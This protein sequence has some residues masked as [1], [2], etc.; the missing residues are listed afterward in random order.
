M[1]K[2]FLI[3][4]VNILI[5]HIVSAQSIIG[6]YAIQNTVSGKNLRPYDAGS[7]NGNR[8]VLYNHVEWKCMTWKFIQVKDSTY[9]LRNLFTSKTFQAADNPA[10]EGTSLEQ[11]PVSYDPRQ[12]WEFIKAS[13]NFYYI[14]LKGTG[15][16]ITASS[17]Q[18]NSNIVLQE[19]QSNA[20]QMWR[21]VAQNPNM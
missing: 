19:K 16:Y 17:E 11:Q 20:L 12:Q 8:I 7:Q 4:I 14:R 15:F 1:K 6:T 3:F 13:D 2:L 18:T 9:Q 10:K 5:L 21:L